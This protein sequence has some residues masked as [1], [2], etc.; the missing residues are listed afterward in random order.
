MQRLLQYGHAQVDGRSSG[1]TALKLAEHSHLFDDAELLYVTELAKKFGQNTT[2]SLAT[3]LV[4]FH[5]STTVSSAN[6]F[7]TFG[8][9]E[10]QRW[11]N[12][13]RWMLS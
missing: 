13:Y 4:G 3:C 2:S 1:W 10:Y 6:G 9:N 7:N 11:N 12:E 5:D 8:R